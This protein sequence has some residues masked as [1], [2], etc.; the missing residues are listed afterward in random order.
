[1][2]VKNFRG[3]LDSYK[4]LVHFGLQKIS[5]ASSGVHFVKDNQVV[6]DVFSPVEDIEDRLYKS[7]I[8]SI[9]T[10]ID[11]VKEKGRFFKQKGS[12]CTYCEFKQQCNAGKL[13]NLELES[14]N[15]LVKYDTI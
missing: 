5:G 15:I 7:L 2:G 10:A 8:F 1:M 3:Q 9:E 13:S 14:A 12:Q 6:L 11:V 4:V